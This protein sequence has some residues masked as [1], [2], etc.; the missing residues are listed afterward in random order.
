MG[1]NTLFRKFLILGIILLFIGASFI[2]SINSNVIQT[3]V[4]N[5]NSGPQTIVSIIN[6][7]MLDLEYI[8]NITRDLS[9]IIFTEYN[10]SAGELAKG[11]SF[12]TKGEH[13][14][15][16][17]LYDNLTELGLFTIKE[18]IKNIPRYPRLTYAYETLD[19]KMILTN[20]TS[21]SNETVDCQ[22]TPLKLD[23]ELLSTQLECNFSYIGLKIKQKPESVYEWLNARAYD[24]KGKDYVFIKESGGVLDRNPNASLP[25][26][27]KLLRRFFYPIRTYPM[28]AWSYL[29]RNIKR[30]IL[31][32]FFSHCRGVIIY[33][34]TND[35]HNT[36]S[37]PE[38]K[39]PPSLSINGSTGR[40]IIQDIENF[41]VDFYVK[42]RYNKSVISYN[43][44]GQLNG[45]DPSKT[46]IV[47]CLYD[48]VWCQGTG[49]SAIG[50]AIVL[51]IAKYFVD[52]NITPKYN[53]KFIGFGGEE[54]GLRGVK[55]YE[56]T[57][58]GEDIIYVIDMN[59]VGFTQDYPRLQLNLLVNKLGFMNEIWKVAKR[60]DYVKRT[61]DTADI[62]KKWWPS[63]A[64]SDDQLFAQNRP[65]R[66]KT[67]C[68]LK[69]FP[70]IWHHRD[71]LGHTAG[72]V[73]DYF[74]WRDVSA[75]GEIAL[76]I[77][78]YLTV[79][80]N[81]QFKT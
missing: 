24:R 18:Q 63:G 23:P 3:E 71:G 37:N 48:S 9:Y 21:N 22:I 5:N 81:E 31:H 36:G 79:N 77:T 59:Q 51:G 16:K 33:D 26:D 41:T 30:P 72:D 34:F 56:A 11:R 55:Y 74:D 10:E 40:R 68:F 35:T 15:A 49:D 2:P 4:K 25:L 47:D 12:G 46:V 65:F 78:R 57:H 80:P 70:W 28:V 6:E 62:A 54:A 66:C 75:T 32:K 13:K 19:F 38:G 52:Y 27:V 29:K 43:V 42:Q 44:I 39:M 76:N 69:D 58:K 50:M 64:P 60:T 67:V 45:T 53:I 1:K 61:G 17:I 8:Y 7:S 73:L 14:A 20:K